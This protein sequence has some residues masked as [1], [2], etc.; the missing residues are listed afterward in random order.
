MSNTTTIARPYAKA[1]FELALDSKKL[2]R[3][4]EILYELAVAVSDEEAMKF[5][6]NPAATA[7]QQ[8]EVL[9]SLFAKADATEKT[10]IE[11]LVALLADNKRLM[12]LPNIKVLFDSLR[13][14]QEKTLEVNVI[15]FSELSTA[16]QAQLISSLS[17]RLQREVTINLKVDKSLLGGAVIHAGDLIIDGSVRGKLDK[18]RTDLAA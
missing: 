17:K 15:S 6:A 18:L 2:G 5:I 11:N 4:S 9:M 10:T 16:Q 7:E 13:A 12:V 1:L 14:E 3:W 8:T